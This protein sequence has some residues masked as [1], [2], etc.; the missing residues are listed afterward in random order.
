MAV[1]PPRKF[2]HVFFIRANPANS[3]AQLRSRIRRSS[4]SAKAV[5][6]PLPAYDQELSGEEESA[7]L[8]EVMQT[9]EQIDEYGGAMK[10]KKNS[11]QRVFRDRQVLGEWNR[12][13]MVWMIFSKKWQTCPT[14]N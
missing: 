1:K 3:K 14:M 4:H 6:T 5:S 11:K 10:S 9:G 7:V 12:E 8:E 2:S 13:T